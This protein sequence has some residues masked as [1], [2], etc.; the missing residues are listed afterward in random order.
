[1]LSYG[2]CQTYGIRLVLLLSILLLST[3]T[4]C[5]KQEP[6]AGKPNQTE[7][8]TAEAPVQPVEG[9]TFTL[10]EVDTADL[11]VSTLPFP[12]LGARAKFFRAQVFIGGEQFTAYCTQRTLTVQ[13]QAIQGF[14]VRLIS[15]DY[16]PSQTPPYWLVNHPIQMY[17]QI[18]GVPYACSIKEDRSAVVFTPYQGEIGTLKISCGDRVVN[19]VSIISCLLS[20]EESAFSLTKFTGDNI[21]VPVGDYTYASVSVDFDTLRIDTSKNRYK[22]AGQ[23]E[24]FEEEPLRVSKDRVLTYDFSAKPE[25]LFTKITD[26]MEFKLGDDVKMAAVLVD[27]EL[28][29]MVSGLYDNSKKTTEENKDSSGKVVRTYEQMEALVPTVQITRADGTLMAEGQMPFG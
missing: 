5:R 29:T 20:S 11:D 3:Q 2:K 15:K 24:P 1:M 25:V 19:D 28:D 8:S 6:E 21:S 9:L 23:T 26:G 18:A 10:E 14:W 12:D 17:Q 13:D 16:T 22:D 4:N 27:T 7:K